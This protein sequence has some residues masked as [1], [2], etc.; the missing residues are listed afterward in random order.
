MLLT[1]ITVMLAMELAFA[2]FMFTPRLREVT[3]PDTINPV[4]TLILSWNGGKIRKSL[5]SPLGAVYGLNNPEQ[6]L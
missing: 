3:A 4:D 5:Y 2:T 6:W 1:H